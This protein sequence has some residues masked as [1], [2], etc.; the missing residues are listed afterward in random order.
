MME[1]PSSQYSKGCKWTIMCCFPP[2]SCFLADIIL[3]FNP[4]FLAPAEIFIYLEAKG[5]N[6][7][8]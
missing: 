5:V 1:E 4:H 2:F 7:S 6:Q 8:S 3:V